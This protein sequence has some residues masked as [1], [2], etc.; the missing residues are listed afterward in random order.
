M[1]IA[2]V[3]KDSIHVFINIEPLNPFKTVRVNSANNDY[4]KTQIHIIYDKLKKKT[5]FLIKCIYFN[6]SK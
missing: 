5:F 2:F 4:F 1:E 3:R 6:T